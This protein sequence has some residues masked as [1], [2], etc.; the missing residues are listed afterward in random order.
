MTVGIAAISE[1]EHDPY[2]VLAADR[3]V[4]NRTGGLEYEAQESKIETLHH[5]QD[6]TAVALGAGRNDWLSEIV[7]KANELIAQKATANLNVTDINS[8]F[9]IAYQ[10]TIQNAI[11]D[12]LLA[13]LGFQLSDLRNKE[14]HMPEQI[15]AEIVSRSQKYRKQFA[16]GAQF[17]LAGVDSRGAH[18]YS[19]SGGSVSEESHRGYSVI[20]SGFRSAQLTFVR[21]NFDKSTSL[22]DT[23]FTVAEAKT[24]SE[25]RQG[26]GNKMDLVKISVGKYNEISETEQLRNQLTRVDEEE[27]LARQNVMKEWDE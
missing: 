16:E 17:I 21:S 13:P 12:E 7:K 20:G 1:A 2:V 22:T 23:L 19:H 10:R 11:H 24:Q 15:Q 18:I 8:L 14:E 9:K 5:Q 26:V 6:A 27:R 3:M 4:T 25:E